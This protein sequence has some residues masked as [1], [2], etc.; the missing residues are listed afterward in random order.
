[1]LLLARLLRVVLL[2]N[3]LLKI[4]LLLSRL[5]GFKYNRYLKVILLLDSSQYSLLQYK[6]SRWLRYYRG[7]YLHSKQCYN[8]SYRLSRLLG[9]RYNRYLR[10]I[11]LLGSGQYSLLGYKCNRQLRCFKGR[12]LCSKQC[13]SY[14]YRLS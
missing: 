13:C 2:L 14:S 4:I 11:L 12:C 9:Y 10:V 8:Y 3:R 6:Y 7:K 5:L 1:M